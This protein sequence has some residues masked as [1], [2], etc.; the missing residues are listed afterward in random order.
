MLSECLLAVDRLLA[1]SKSIDAL[2]VSFLPVDCVL[3]GECKFLILRN[4]SRGI[5]QSIQ[6]ETHESDSDLGQR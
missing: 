2:R 4:R 5:A 1:L 3:V 6:K